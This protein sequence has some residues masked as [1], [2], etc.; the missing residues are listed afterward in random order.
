[1][2]CDGLQILLTDIYYMP[3]KNISTNYWTKKY[4]NKK[5]FSAQILSKHKQAKNFNFLT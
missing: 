2:R 4:F 3:E 5:F 1:M